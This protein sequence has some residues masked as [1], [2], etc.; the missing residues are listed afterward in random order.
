VAEQVSDEPPEAGAVEATAPADAAAELEAARRRVAQLE[1]AN[2]ELR[3]VNGELARQRIGRSDSAAA[4]AIHRATAAER[5]LLRAESWDHWPRPMRILVSMVIRL[6]K[7]A[8]RLR[9]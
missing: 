5:E 7:L 9:G 3:R 1:R 2:A 8:A 6:R 4:S